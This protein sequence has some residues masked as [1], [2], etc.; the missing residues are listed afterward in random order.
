MATVTTVKTF[1][2]A[3]LRCPGFPA[4]RGTSHSSYSA[5]FFFQHLEPTLFLFGIVFIEVPA[6]HLNWNP[7]I[8]R[9]KSHREKS[10][11]IFRNFA[12]CGNKKAVIIVI[13]YE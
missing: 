4:R 10:Y 2:E 13:D 6:L 3:Y 11:V 9:L 7:K 5:T 12:P 8:S 1:W